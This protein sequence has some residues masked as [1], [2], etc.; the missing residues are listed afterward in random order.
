MLVVDPQSRA[1][2]DQVAGNPWLQEGKEDELFPLSSDDTTV[3]NI[4]ELPPDETDLILHRMEM[5]GY[6]TCEDILQ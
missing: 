3:S 5:G 6:G 4:N 1:S 2:L